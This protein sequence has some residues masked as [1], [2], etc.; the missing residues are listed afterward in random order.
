[1]MLPLESGPARMRVAA[2][3]NPLTNVVEAE[4]TL[5]GGTLASADVFYGALAAAAVCAIGLVVGVRAIRR[6]TV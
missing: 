2:T 4:R 1:M 5:F 3:V 6:S